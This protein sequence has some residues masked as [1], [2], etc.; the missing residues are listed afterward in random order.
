VS[1]LLAIEVALFRGKDAEIRTS[2]HQV[3]VL[4]RK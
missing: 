2:H 1:G 3:T 4:P